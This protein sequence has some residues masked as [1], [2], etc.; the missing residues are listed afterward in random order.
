[1]T[2]A[3][4]AGKNPRLEAGKTRHPIGLAFSLEGV[5]CTEVTASLPDSPT[6]LVVED[7]EDTRCAVRD[8]LTDNGLH[9]T[10]AADGRAA[11]DV[12]TSGKKP[13]VVVLDLDMPRMSGVELLDIMRRYETLMRVPVVVFSGT[14]RKVSGLPVVRVIAK[15][16]SADALLDAVRTHATG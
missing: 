15:A 11:L 3:R 5:F 6:V 14:D 4:R 8:L 9:V 13:A 2:A 16:E 1:M 12:L 7:D 10:E